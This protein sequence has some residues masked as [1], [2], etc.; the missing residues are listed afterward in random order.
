MGKTQNPDIKKTALG[1]K[2]ATIFSLS[3]RLNRRWN[4][5][6]DSLKLN[7][8]GN[9]RDWDEEAGTMRDIMNL[10]IDVEKTLRDLGSAVS[11]ETERQAGLLERTYKSE[12]ARLKREVR[13]LNEE[14]EKLATKITNCTSVD[15][16]EV[17]ADKVESEDVSE[18]R[19]M[20]EYVVL[21]LDRKYSLIN[22]S[23]EVSRAMCELTMAEKKVVY[24]QKGEEYLFNLMREA[25]VKESSIKAD[26]RKIKRELSE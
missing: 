8:L 9:W 12:I 6:R 16:V 15:R 20:L 24:K 14:N 4:K 10:M 5:V 1:Q 18:L 3:D 26:I 23:G 21:R 7:K 22:N 2:V 25:G 19:A 11:E 17:S 13:E